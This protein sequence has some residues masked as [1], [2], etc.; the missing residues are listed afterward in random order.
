MSLPVRTWVGVLEMSAPFTGSTAK[1][2]SG[3]VVWLT[4]N[5]SLAIPTSEEVNKASVMVISIPFVLSTFII[6]LEAYKRRVKKWKPIQSSKRTLIAAVITV[7]C[8]LGYLMSVVFTVKSV[9]TLLEH[10]VNQQRF[11][12]KLIDLASEIHHESSILRRSALEL[13]TELGASGLSSER[14]MVVSVQAGVANVESAIKTIALIDGFHSNP[15][16]RFTSVLSNI[17]TVAIS[18]GVACLL[19][20]VTLSMIWKGISSRMLAICLLVYVF[21]GTYFAGLSLEISFVAGRG[22]QLGPVILAALYEYPAKTAAWWS[23]TSSGPSG[24]IVQAAITSSRLMNDM[25]NTILT[26]AKTEAVARA[27]RATLGNTT[28]VLERMDALELHSSCVSFMTSVSRSIYF[29]SCEVLPS[30]LVLGVVSSLLLVVSVSVLFYLRVET[31]RRIPRPGS[32]PSSAV[33]VYQ[34]IEYEEQVEGH[35][36]DRVSDEHESESG[37]LRRRLLDEQTAVR[38]FNEKTGGWD[39]SSLPPVAF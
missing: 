27:A 14:D 28:F 24:S 16:D 26:E 15:I 4:G 20:S 37:T 33:S 9:D 23:C 38:R 19:A 3:A 39:A 11:F 2:L 34:H 1:G 30:S 22:C 13:M 5:N 7:L 31:S 36:S 17:K 29:Q 12:A 21:A 32:V 10:R 35:P 8:L 6:C 18:T 25:A